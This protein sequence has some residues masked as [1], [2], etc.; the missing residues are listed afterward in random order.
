VPKVPTVGSGSPLN[1]GIAP[2]SDAH[3]TES[4]YN[5]LLQVRDAYYTARKAVAELHSQLTIVDPREFEQVT[6][7]MDTLV[8]QYGIMVDNWRYALNLTRV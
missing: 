5:Q 8:L 1:S 2:A 4:N 6:S 7:I 3:A